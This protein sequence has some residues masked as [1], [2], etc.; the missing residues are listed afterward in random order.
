M[1]RRQLRRVCERR[2]AIALDSKL[3]QVRQLRQVAEGHDGA[4]L[5]EQ[6]AH[7]GQ[8]AERIADAPARY[9]NRR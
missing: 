4:V 1:E 7:L 2:D 8:V 5:Q 3:L 9:H 6:A